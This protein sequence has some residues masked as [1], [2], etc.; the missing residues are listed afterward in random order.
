MRWRCGLKAAKYSINDEPLKE[1][2]MPECHMK[3][4][5][6]NSLIDNEALMTFKRYE[7][8]SVKSVRVDVLL[9]NLTV[10]SVTVLRENI[11]IP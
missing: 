9:D 11:L 4:Q 2:E 8:G 3:Y 1:L 6:P 10:Q 5:Q 7:L